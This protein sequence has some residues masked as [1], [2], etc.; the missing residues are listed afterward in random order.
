MFS[1]ALL[2]D[3]PPDCYLMKNPTEFYLPGVP[4]YDPPVLVFRNDRC[5]EVFK[6]IVF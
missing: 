1:L 4:G 5:L 2:G 6:I 3:I